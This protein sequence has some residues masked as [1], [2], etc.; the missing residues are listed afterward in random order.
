VQDDAEDEWLFGS[1]DRPVRF[2]YVHLRMVATCFDDQLRVM[3]H[4]FKNLNPGGYIE[5]F[6]TLFQFESV[7]DTI[8]GGQKENGG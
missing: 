2:D 6:D 3:R 7:G 4:A 5:Y 1:T 8:E